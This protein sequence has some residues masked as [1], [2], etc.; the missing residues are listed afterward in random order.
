MSQLDDLFRDGLGARKADLSNTNDLWARINAAKNAPVPTGEALDKTFRDGL[1][2]REAAVPSGMWARIVAARGRRPLAK[3]LAGAAAVLLLLVA[4][5]IGYNWLGDE[6]PVT[7]NGYRNVNNPANDDGPTALHGT[8]NA[9]PVS[10]DVQNG[11]AE[12]SASLGTLRGS[13]NDDTGNNLTTDAS[14]LTKSPAKTGGSTEGPRP[15]AKN[16]RYERRPAGALP[17]TVKNQAAGEDIEAGKVL[18]PRTVLAMGQIGGK[19]ME[20]VSF[21][22]ALPAVAVV[23]GKFKSTTALRGLQTELLFG[24]SYSRQELAIQDP[25]ATELQ[26]LRE[27]SE[28]PK[29]GYQ[30]TLRSS[31]RFTDRLRLMA[32]LTYAEIR[33]ELDYDRIVNGSTIRLSTTNHIR[34]LEAPVLLGYTIPGRRLNV[35]VNGGPLLNLTTGVRGRFLAP[36]SSIPLD[37]Q[38][39]GNFRG[40]IG[41]GFMASLT[42]AYQIGKKRP[43]T[44]LL[45]PFF[46]AYPTAFTEKGAPLREKYWVAGLQLGVRK[47]L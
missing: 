18:T 14:T 34:M 21:E 17:V 19:L 11:R 42:T 24:V 26:V 13:D 39:D 45:E 31:Y 10:D 32:G 37:L 28:F 33:N 29:A 7:D 1:G 12:T 38:T 9:R 35:T 25:S 27:A 43:F 15:A 44:L 41:V 3:W 30:I 40:N 22:E 8:D 6:L 5:G 23:P 47:R 4:G 46:K 20:S 2:D 36:S 16:P